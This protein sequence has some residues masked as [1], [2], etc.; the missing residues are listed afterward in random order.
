MCVYWQCT[1]LQSARNAL[2]AVLTATTVYC[3][4]MRAACMQWNTFSDFLF[5]LRLVKIH[6]TLCSLL[7]L[8]IVATMRLVGLLLLGLAAA[9]ANLNASKSREALSPERALGQSCSPPVSGGPCQN[10]SKCTLNSAGCIYCTGLTM[11]QCPVAY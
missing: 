5:P 7:I 9:H 8:C 3:N 10:G 11:L 4:V 6:T 2:P 1:T